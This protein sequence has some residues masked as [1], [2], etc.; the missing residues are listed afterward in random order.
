MFDFLN[1]DGDNISSVITLRDKDTKDVLFYGHNA[2]HIGNLIVA[3]GNSFIGDNS[4]FL[5]T[6]AFGSGATS[7]TP[8]G[9]VFYRNKNVSSMYDPTADLY[10]LTYQKTFSNLAS[11]NTV[12]GNNVMGVI[13]EQGHFDLNIVSTL[14]Y[15]EP[16]QQDLEAIGVEMDA[17]YVFDEIALKT[18]NGL[19]ISHLIMHPIMKAA[20]RAIEVE[21]TVR[22]QSST[23]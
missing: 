2:I 16:S 7:I 1:L 14:D 11:T 15:G 18:N 22:L 20:N 6:M 12:V 19:M 13:S 4:Y 10:N 21:Y 9:Q 17:P 23:E 5:D 8:D 3:L